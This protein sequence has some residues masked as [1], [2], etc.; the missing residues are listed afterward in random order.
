MRFLGREQ[1][2]KFKNYIIHCSVNEDPTPGEY[3]LYN[4]IKPKS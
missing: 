3:N 4:A 2:K 1:L